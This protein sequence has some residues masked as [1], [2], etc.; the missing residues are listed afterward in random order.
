M[1]HA[2]RIALTDD[3]ALAYADGGGPELAELC[4]R[5]RERAAGPLVTYSP[6]VFIPLTHLCRDVCHYCTFARPPRRG[7][8]CYM[9]ADEVLAIAEQGRRAGC[10]EALFTLGDKP[11]LRY[12]AAREELAA[13]GFPTTAAYLAHCAGLV[14]RETGL[15]PH[16]N[17]GILDDDELLALREVCASQGIMLETASARLSQRGGPH[18]G[19]PDKLPEVRLDAI[20]RAGRLAIPYTSGIL[21]GIGETRRE[22][23]EALLALRDLH[24]RH[25]HLQ[26]VIVQ[27]FRAKPHTK[28]ADAP[29]PSLEDHLWTI[30]L[31]RLLLPPGGRDTGAAQPGARRVPAPARGRHRR[32]RRRLPC[33]ARPRQPGGPVARALAARGSGSRGRT[34][35]GAAP[36]RLSALPARGRA[37]AGAGACAAPR[38][39][40]RTRTDW[41]AT[42]APGSPAPAP[43]R[44]PPG[45]AAAGRSW[46]A[47]SRRPSSG[48]STAASAAPIWTRPTRRRC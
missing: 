30:A 45:R 37:L 3:E 29:E 28:M 22:R 2:L 46:R 12:R 32:L 47:P 13:L 16:A 40:P 20:D 25:G 26:E 38:W 8:R 43:S 17:P 44:R 36:V 39:R 41:H 31:A 24:A 4:E 35:A 11:E 48:R 14:L 42:R 19:S 21:I 15:L 10:H 1:S 18:F 5:A 23:I 27:N 34:H 9:T 33:D 6:K 7:E